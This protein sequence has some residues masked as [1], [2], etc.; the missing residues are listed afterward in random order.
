MKRE[1]LRSFVATKRNK[2][3]KEK[4]KIIIMEEKIKK[5]KE[6]YLRLKKLISEDNVLLLVH[7]RYK[8]LHKLLIY[9]LCGISLEYFRKAYKTGKIILQSGNFGPRIGAPIPWQEVFL[10]EH[11]QDK[12]SKIDIKS[13]EKRITEYENILFGMN[14]YYQG[15]CFTWE[16]NKEIIELNSVHYKDIEK[17]IATAVNNA[18]QL[19][20]SIKKDSDN[21]L[22]IQQFEFPPVG[23]NPILDEGTKLAKAL[24]E[25]Y[26]E[27][28]PG[29]PRTNH[30]TR[31]ESQRLKTAAIEKI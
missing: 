29:R 2:S 8:G 26:E 4:I 19:L 24:I 30:L 15:I 13:F 23:G 6:S 1:N 10:V 17:R 21:L 5:E 12:E 20:E 25:A 18:K 16:N 31:E 7:K 3:M 22:L 28:F 27:I 9:C 11:K 14:L